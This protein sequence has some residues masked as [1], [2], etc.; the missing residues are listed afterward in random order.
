MRNIK[1]RTAFGVKK[2]NSV[3]LSFFY[4]NTPKSFLNWLLYDMKYEKLP[5]TMLLEYEYECTENKIISGKIKQN[6]YCS[7][8]FNW[9]RYTCPFLFHFQAFERDKKSWKFT[10]G[11]HAQTFALWMKKKAYFLLKIQMIFTSVLM[12]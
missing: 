10:F 3:V 8:S 5:K 7:S 1:S 11:N 12:N 2:C 6:Y 4:I 9:F